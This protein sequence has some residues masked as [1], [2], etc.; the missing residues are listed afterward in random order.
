MKFK[1]TELSELVCTRISHDLIGNIGALSGA[2]ELIQENGG[3]LDDDAMAILTTASDTLKARQKLFRLAFGVDSKNTTSEEIRRICADYLHS[4][5][6]R[7]SSIELKEGKIPPELAKI[8]CLCVL[9]GAE[10]CI[11][12]GVIEVRLEGEKLIIHTASE[13]KL[14]AAKIAVYQEIAAG[15][16]PEEN[17]SQYVQLLYLRAYLGENVPLSITAD[18]NTMTVIVG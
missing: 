4:V 10:V 3:A 13:Y 12:G 1:Q 11:K 7:N 18:E 17:T 5:S 14:A 15:K 8:W 9:I 6:G 16:V 2:L